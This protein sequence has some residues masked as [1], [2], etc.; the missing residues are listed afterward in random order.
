L[1]LTRLH[2]HIYE[3]FE[4]A[5]IAYREVGENFAIHVNARQFQA[6][7]QLVVRCTLFACGG[8]DA[9]NP[10]AAKFAFAVMPV[11][12][13]IKKRMGQSF[14]RAAIEKVTRADLPFGL[15]QYFF[16]TRTRGHSTFYARHF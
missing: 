7:H 3:R 2:C 11:T 13:M 12:V 9:R 4:R 16:V 10:K 8:V 15:F 14:M 6:V 1:R 5:G